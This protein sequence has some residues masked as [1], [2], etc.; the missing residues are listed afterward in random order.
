MPRV[1]WPLLH[2]Q[3]RVQVVLTLTVEGE[4][5]T[6][7]LLADTGAGSANAKFDL[8]LDEDDCLLCGGVFFSHVVL[9]GAYTGSHPI[10][11]IRVQIP[12][13]NFDQD[14]YVVG[15]PVPP[16]GFD[17]IA[18]FRFLNRFSYGNFGDPGQFGLEC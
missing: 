6:R 5:L 11:A 4:Q 1:V 2:D 15:V 14:V 7:D 8:I 18:C 10:Y 9:G 13:L 12:A 3:P 17:G 16:A